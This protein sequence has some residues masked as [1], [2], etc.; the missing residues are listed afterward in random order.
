MKWSERYPDL[1]G[2]VFD[3]WT[4]IGKADRRNGKRFWRCRCVCGNESEV[5]TTSL[6]RGCSRSC[7]CI[8]RD[9]FVANLVQKP[10][11]ERKSPEFYVWVAMIQRCYDVN[12]RAFHHY[13]G[14]GITV[15]KRWHDPIEGGKKYRIEC[16]RNFLSD[17]GQRPS[18]KHSIDRYPNNNGNYEPGNCRW[19]T[20]KEQMLNTRKAAFVVFRGIRRP[21][22]DIAQEL[23]LKPGFLCKRIRKGFT[24][25]EAISIPA[26]WGYDCRR[27]REIYR[28][29]D[30]R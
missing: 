7:G 20:Q 15:C 13:G 21:I 27:W 28:Q 25:E 5:M 14:R 6:L 3:R 10:V 17:M 18:A 23:G 12:H 22:V 8:A 2:Q 30:H 11:P 29:V 4:V 26:I 24:I 19:A 16:Y 1:T 9:Y